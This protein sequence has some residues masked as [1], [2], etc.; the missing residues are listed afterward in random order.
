MANETTVQH[1]SASLTLN[2]N[3]DSD[4]RDDTETFLNRIV[5]EVFSITKIDAFVTVLCWQ[6]TFIPILNVLMSLLG[7]IGAVEAYSWGLVLGHFIFI[8]NIHNLFLIF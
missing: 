2:E 3:Y 4:V 6:H 1:T 5:P 8:P 7:V